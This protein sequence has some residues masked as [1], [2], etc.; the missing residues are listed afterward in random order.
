MF[1][2]GHLLLDIIMP[3]KTLDEILAPFRQSFAESGMTEEELDVLIEEARKEVWEE[4]QC[5]PIIIE[6]QR[7]DS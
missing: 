7:G 1:P 6:A 2:L 3:E 5:Q 4:K